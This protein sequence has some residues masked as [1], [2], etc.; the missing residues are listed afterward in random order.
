MIDIGMAIRK[1]YFDV[2]KDQLIV[3]G[4][5]IPITDEKLDIDIENVQ[6][7]VLMT[8]QDEDLQNKSNKTHFAHELLNKLQIVHQRKATNTKEVVEDV[9][10]Q[11]LTLLFPSRTKWNVSL[12]APLHLVYARLQSANYNPVAQTVDGFAISKILTFK[13]RITQH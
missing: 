13:N 12:P 11:I 5:P 10:S 8:S 3:G 4:Q 7:Y 6:V 2:L 9:S 1:A